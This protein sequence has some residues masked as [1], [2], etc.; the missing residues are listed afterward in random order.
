MTTENLTEEATA[1]LHRMLDVLVD[2][3]RDLTVE[4]REHRGLVHW[5]VVANCND[6]GKIVGKNGRHARAIKHLMQEIGQRHGCQMVVRI[7][8][9]GPGERLPDAPRR[10]ADPAY[11]PAIHLQLLRDWLD[12]LCDERPTVA[13]LR[14]GTLFDFIIRPAVVQDFDRLQLPLDPNAESVMGSLSTLFNAAGRRDGAIF[15]LEVQ[16]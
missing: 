5:K 8:P 4:P 16:A 6:I 12:A 3:P 9:E 7:E 10:V 13:V 15:R 2:Y 1:L 11:S 14:Q